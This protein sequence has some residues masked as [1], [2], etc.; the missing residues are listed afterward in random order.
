MFAVPIGVS[1]G[2]TTVTGIGFTNET[3]I[4]KNVNAMPKFPIGFAASPVQA[5]MANGAKQPKLSGIS[6]TYQ[7]FYKDFEWFWES[8]G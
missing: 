5:H 2:T 1:G 7:T 4:V 6:G 3:N 8:L